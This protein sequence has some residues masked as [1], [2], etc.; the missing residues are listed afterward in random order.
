MDVV[1]KFNNE[2]LDGKRLVVV[3]ETTEE[4]HGMFEVLQN[5]YLRAFLF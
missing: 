5:Q 2:R 4:G 1:V 3:V